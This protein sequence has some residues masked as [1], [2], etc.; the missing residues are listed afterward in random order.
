MLSGASTWWQCDSCAVFLQ[1]YL[2]ANALE[3][4]FAYVR[5]I[6]NVRVRLGARQCLCTEDD[7]GRQSLPMYDV[8]H[9]RRSQAAAGRLLMYDVRFSMCD[10]QIMRSKATGGER[11]TRM[12]CPTGANGQDGTGESICELR[13]GEFG[14]YAANLTNE[15]TASG[16]S[17]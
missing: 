14:G 17:L 4:A 3:N 15:K 10:L 12:R 9:A 5:S 1:S 11:A 7:G 2:K 6:D 13:C 16:P 8:Q